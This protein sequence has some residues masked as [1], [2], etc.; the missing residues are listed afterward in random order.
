MAI[1]DFLGRWVLDPASSRYT[2]GDLP[3][4]A[5]LEI[6]RDGERLV[7]HIAWV[8]GDG[9]RQTVTFAAVPDGR[10]TPTDVPGADTFALDLVDD[11]R[12]D[13]W[14][15]RDGDVVARATR[16]LSPDG[17]RLT[18][19]QTAIVPSGAHDDLSVY[20]RTDRPRA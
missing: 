14:A 10:P 13:S 16:Q 4:E 12:L 5:A 2:F 15:S 19:V 9:R 3:A 18:I 11:R 1:D 7:V 17:R 20:V 6:S 8:D